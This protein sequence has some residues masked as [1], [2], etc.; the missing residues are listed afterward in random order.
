MLHKSQKPPPVL[1]PPVSKPFSRPQVDLGAPGGPLQ[2]PGPEFGLSGPGQQRPFRPQ[3]DD[4]FGPSRGMMGDPMGPPGSRGPPG[5]AP[6]RSGPPSSSLGN[7]PPMGFNDMQDMDL[8]QRGRARP[9]PPGS[10]D[11][12]MRG[13]P[14][15]GDMDLRQMPGGPGPGPRATMMGDVTASGPRDPRLG[16]PP[17]R[18]PGMDFDRFSGDKIPP[19]DRFAGSA[20]NDRDMRDG[21]Y[22]PRLER[23]GG[24]MEGNRPPVSAGGG[25]PGLGPMPKFSLPSGAAPAAG[26]SPD[27]EKAALIMQVLQ[28]SDEQI[29]LLPQE[30]RHSIMVLKSQIAKS[31][32]P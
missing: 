22:D 5:P 4:D 16:G 2:P 13:P 31:A 27:Q 30:Q 21:R 12:D 1:E 25:I 14:R 20:G 32:N 24:V 26:Q 7:H 19:H 17:S 3:R 11:M 29:A 23:G 10:G 28:L 6:F 8:R 15:G 9:G 18:P